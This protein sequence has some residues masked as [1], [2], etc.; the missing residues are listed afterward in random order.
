[1]FND[2]KK[3]L[4]VTDLDGTLLPHDKILS[5]KDVDAINYF[6]EKGGSFSIATGRHLNA[7]SYYLNE[8]KPN[9]PVILYNGAG[10]YNFSKEKFVYTKLISKRCKKL[11][12][13]VL[14]RFPEFSAEVATCDKLFTLQLNDVEKHH[15]SITRVTPVHCKSID[16]ID[17]EWLN[18]LFAV[19]PEDMEKLVSYIDKEKYSDMTFVKSSRFFYEIL[20][21]HTSKGT[22]LDVLKDIENLHDYTIVAAGDFNNDIELLKNADVGVAPANASED[23]KAIADIVLDKTCDENA[24]AKVIEYIFTQIK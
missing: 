4:L 2:I 19:M 14:S 3:V 1:M 7:V 22:A 18:A 13:D 12:T 11:I 10:I 8:L 6:I 24:I 5:K 9:K 20:P 15:N 21:E 23:V 16:E 17:G